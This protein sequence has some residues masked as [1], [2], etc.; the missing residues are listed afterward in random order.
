MHAILT[1]P[2]NVT[3]MHQAYTNVP[4]V[5]QMFD[6]CTAAA[7][8]LGFE[9][10]RGVCV[11]P[12]MLACELKNAVCVSG[13]ARVGVV[14]VDKSDTTRGMNG[15]TNGL[16]AFMEEE[17][18]GMKR[19]GITPVVVRGSGGLTGDVVKERLKQSLVEAGIQLPEQQAS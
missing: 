2:A 6:A 1:H 9:A 11:G 5:Q 16:S 4:A 8:S 18:R 12:Y 7:T 3:R 17:V 15:K 19:L 14:Y 10:D 13:G